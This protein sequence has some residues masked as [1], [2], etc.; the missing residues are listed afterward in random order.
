[1][2][3]TDEGVKNLLHSDGFHLQNSES[4]EK[5]ITICH[6]NETKIISAHVIWINSYLPG[7]A[8]LTQ[9]IFL[10]QVTSAEIIPSHLE[11]IW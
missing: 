5:N 11:G 9:E 2:A 10:I 7:I 8:S 4:Y 3:W 1:M 6:Q